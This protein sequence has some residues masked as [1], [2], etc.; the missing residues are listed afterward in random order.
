MR[1]AMPKPRSEKPSSTIERASVLSPVKGSLAWLGGKAALDGAC[2]RRRRLKSDD[3]QTVASGGDS[4]LRLG[5]AKSPPEKKV[6][7]L[8]P[9]GFPSDS[10]ARS[11]TQLVG[12]KEKSAMRSVALDLAARKIAFCEVNGDHVIARR[13]VGS[14]VALEDTLG[15]DCAKARVAIE[16]CREAWFVHATLT[17]WGHEVVVVDTTRVKQ[18]GIGQHGRKTDRIDAEVLARALER[19]SIPVAHVLSP[20]RQKLRLEL[21][22]RRALIETRA[23]Y[24]TTVRH[25]VRTRGEQIAGCDVNRFVRRARA[26]AL[27][28]ETH[29]LIEPLISLIVAVEEQLLAVEQRIDQL[30]AKETVVQRLT[31]VPGVGVIIAAAFVSVIDDA[32]R[33]AHAHQIGSYLGLVPNENSSGDRRRLGAITKRG[34]TYMRFLLVQ[35][36]W[37]LVRSRQSDDPLKRW[38]LALAERR[39]K[40]IAIVALARRLAGLLWAMWR[41]GTVYDSRVTA[42]SS[43]KGLRRQA[44][45]TELRAAALERAASTAR[46]R[47]QM[48]ATMLRHQPTVAS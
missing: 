19:G 1:S 9:A 47:R 21:G 46:D 23:Q 31:T 22:I 5:S 6:A 11:E 14:L 48:L 29:A 41:D 27:S 26:A 8:S 36:A 12:L 37:C 32:K 43:A 18:L 13:T 45:S 3:G 2:A 20:E 34:N 30:C 4:G 44:Q 15:P 33:F 38:T 7:D 16:A 40:R 10:P 39:G 24:V 35:A 42:Q 28:D 25:L 17:R